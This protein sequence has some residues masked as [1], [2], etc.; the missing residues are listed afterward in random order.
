MT[1]NLRAFYQDM[2]GTE[3]LQN[4][5]LEANR[6]I[7]RALAPVIKHVIDGSDEVI[8]ETLQAFL[9]QISQAFLSSLAPSEENLAAQPENSLKDLRE[10]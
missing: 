7:S 5:K 6:I 10:A 1:L 4:S 3:G 2:D 8:G 9:L